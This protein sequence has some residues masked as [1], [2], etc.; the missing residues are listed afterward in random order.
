MKKYSILILFGFLFS[1][2]LIYSQVS[3]IPKPNAI[4]S[5]DGNFNFVKGL[6]LKI[7]RGDEGTKVLFKQLQDY[8]KLHNIP[9]V[10]FSTTTLTINLLQSGTSDMPPEGYV[11][12]IFPNNISITSS[13]NAG[14]YYG[15]QTLFQILDQDAM[16]ILPCMEI[17]DRPAFSYRGFQID[18]SRHFFKV[19]VI[20]QYLDVM[21]K[22][23]M[24][25]FHWHLTDDQ[26][27]RIEIKKYPKLTQ[28]GSCRTE[29][30][31]KEVC[32]FYTQD[33]I[34]QVVQYAKD[35]FINVIPEIDLP[36]HSSAVIAAYPEL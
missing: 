12:N 30:D 2:H 14:I 28:T 4:K 22:L 31:G 20:K 35:R 9:I 19:D 27:W 6:D 36:G 11:L 21:A 8:V 23:K 5:K 29:K 32:G 33:E 13:G 3:I 17:T 18:V 25:Q 10:Q 26:G 1:S 24:N 15:M 7:T 16:K 34:K